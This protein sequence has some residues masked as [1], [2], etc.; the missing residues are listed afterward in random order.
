MNTLGSHDVITS[1]FFFI[2]HK[3]FCFV[4]PVRPGGIYMDTKGAV[5]ENTI[6][7]VECSTSSANP[8]SSVGMEL[9]IDEINQKGILAEVTE[10]P[11]L[12][13]AMAKSFVFNFTTDRSQN[14]KSVKC[15]LLWDGTYTRRN[16]KIN[17]NITCE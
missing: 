5:T 2:I 14:G 16:L 13:H 4:I 6:Q 1:E 11:S 8:V 12:Y 7:S 15:H 3:V 17:L 10:T 9:F